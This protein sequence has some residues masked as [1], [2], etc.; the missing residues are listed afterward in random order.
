MA[1]G[2]ARHGAR[3]RC[4]GRTTN[5]LQAL[6]VAGG[7]LF[8]VTVMTMLAGGPADPDPDETGSSVSTGTPAGAEG[9]AGDGAPTGPPG[10]HGAGALDHRPDRCPHALV[11]DR[12]AGRH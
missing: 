4:R 12:S 9:L 2:A 7:G 11:T 3:K 8:A 1:A 5:A 6:G 10:R